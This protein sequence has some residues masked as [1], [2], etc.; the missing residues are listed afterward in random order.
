MTHVPTVPKLH[1][2]VLAELLEAI[3]RGDHEEGAKLPRATA[4]ADTYS[5]SRPV[6][7]H[8]IHTLR[9]RGLVMVTHVGAFVAPGGAGTSS[10]GAARSDAKRARSSGRAQGGARVRV[11]DLAAR[12]HTRRKATH[13]RGA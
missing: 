8:A 10:T 4:L 1:E 5:V 11:V 6:A 13:S 3:V 2:T 7:R 12:H 9:D